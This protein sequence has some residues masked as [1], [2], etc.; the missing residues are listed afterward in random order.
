MIDLTV[1]DLHI[2]MEALKTERTQMHE[3]LSSVEL[4]FTLKGIAQE[5]YEKNCKVKRIIETYLKNM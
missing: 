2:V 3:A 1:E 4:P 5:K